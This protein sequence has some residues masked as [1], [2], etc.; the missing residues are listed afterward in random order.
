MSEHNDVGSTPAGPPPL[1]PEPADPAPSTAP[2]LATSD[3][4]PAS[5]RHLG[6]RITA[7][8]AGLVLLTSSVGY[9]AVNRYSGRIHQIDVFASMNADDRPPAG[10]GMNIL[11]VGTDQ[12]TGLS[13]AEQKALHVGTGNYG[14]P[15]TDTIMLLHVSQDS[16]AVTVV[17]LPRDSYVDIPA[18]TDSKGVPHEQ[19]KNKLNAAFELG[20]APLV[21]ETVEHATGLHIDH[22]VELN[23]AGFLTMVDALG[24]V[25]VCVRRATVD[26][27][28]GLNLPAGTS[29]VTGKQALAYVRARHIDSDFG[30]MARQQK[31]VASIVQKATSAGTLLNPLALN[32]FLDAATSS[33]TTDS[34]F[35]RDDM[36]ALGNRLRSVNAS[37]ILFFTVPIAKSN[38]RVDI[39]SLKNQST[40][41]WSPDAKDIF[42]RL[43]ADEPLL[44]KPGSSDTVTAVRIA[45]SRVRV[46]VENA[47]GKSGLGRQVADDLAKA[48]YDVVGQPTNARTSGANTTVIEYDPGFNDSLKTLEAAFPNATTKSVP[49]LGSTFIVLAGGDY[50]GVQ[51]VTVSAQ[52]TSSSN[53]IKSPTKLRTAAEAICT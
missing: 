14:P 25:P 23:F 46:R 38:Y 8:V 53:T 5:R 47:S 13:K 52:A 50:N 17:S 1:T 9:A 51:P 39:G 10:S 16:G 19:R 41:L 45:P 36:L 29:E 22:Y 49:G 3:S 31:F 35:S 6:R 40:V 37:D 21:T 24:G 7:G 42:T 12:R 20:G 28:S 4:R 33:V 2:N 26:K 27:A 11:L 48:G 34:G 32:G 44:T 30:R 43:A 15:R 18:Y